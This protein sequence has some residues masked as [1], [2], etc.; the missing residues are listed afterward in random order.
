MHRFPYFEIQ[1]VI[2]LNV[3]TEAISI[4]LSPVIDAYT[5]LRTL[6]VHMVYKSKCIKFTSKIH[7]NQNYK[8]FFCE[9]ERFD[10]FSKTKSLQ[11]KSEATFS[12]LIT[13]I[14]FRKAK[15][16]CLKIHVFTQKW[17]E[18]YR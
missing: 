7:F 18:A 12:T 17:A 3:K 5:E 2:E 6:F 10:D 13:R 11:M 16:K 14:N 9:I 15:Q 4:C 1:S 8:Y